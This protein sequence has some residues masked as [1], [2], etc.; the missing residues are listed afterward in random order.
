MFG[1]KSACNS[2]NVG[3]LTNYWIQTDEQLRI[4]R[5]EQTQENWKSMIRTWNIDDVIDF[6]LNS[7]KNLC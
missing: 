6:F 5:A 4:E 7:K 1:K 2:R 3:T